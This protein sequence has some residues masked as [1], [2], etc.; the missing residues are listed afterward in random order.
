VNPALVRGPKPTKPKP[1]VLLETQE[2]ITEEEVAS[3][4]TIA[5]AVE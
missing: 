2:P 1:S 4:P 3:T 5:T